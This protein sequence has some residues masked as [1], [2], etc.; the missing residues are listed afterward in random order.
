MAGIPT[1]HTVLVTLR[2]GELTLNK[3]VVTI[4]PGAQDDI[5]WIKG[6]GSEP[7]TFCTLEFIDTVH[8][9]INLS[10]QPTKITVDDDNQKTWDYG[11]L[12]W[13]HDA[14]NKRHRTKTLIQ[15][16]PTIKNK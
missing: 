9:F 3:T 6:E 15:T 5:T 8:P 12:I 16:G 2:R 7:F 14:H 13:V 4:E 11:Y 1:H 10:V